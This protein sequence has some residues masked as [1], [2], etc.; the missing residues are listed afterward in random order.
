MAFAM[1]AAPSSA[2][3]GGQEPRPL[4]DPALVAMDQVR[5]VAE[6]LANL[7]DQEGFG[8][9]ALDFDTREVRV[10]WRGTPPDQVAA[11]EGV[12]ADGVRVVVESAPF[13]DREL[14]SKATAL[15]DLGRLPGGVPVQV[16]TKRPD[17]TGL[18]AEITGADLKAAGTIQ[19]VA[20]GLTKTVGVPVDVRLG[21]E[22]TPQTRRNDSAPWQ[23]GGQLRFPGNGAFCTSGFAVLTSGGAGR[24]LT[25]GHCNPA[26]GSRVNDGAGD[27][28]AAAGTSQFAGNYD[29]LLIDPSASPATIGKVFGGPWDA[30]TGHNR[31]QF[32]V[33]GAAPPSVGDTVCVSGANSGEHCNREIVD[34]GVTL[35][36]YGHTCTGFIYRGPGVTTVG[37]DS[38][39]PVYVMRSD[40]RIGARGIHSGGLNTVTCPTDTAVDP[41][42]NC[43][44]R[45]FAIGIHQLTD[46]WNVIVEQD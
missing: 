45:S 4:E 35:N 14:T 42:G 29:S 17:L 21:Q 5:V 27:Q 31:Y 7:Y 33:G 30:G 32:H 20:D 34:T 8:R 46:R 2:E 11:A 39:A 22:L 1:L 13:S 6:P 9:V 12:N 41:D 23:G 24:L 28:I 26:A 3:P 44:S 36:C 10:A 25:A 37:G 15:I 43:S 19:E 18:V 40:G 16:V 38:G